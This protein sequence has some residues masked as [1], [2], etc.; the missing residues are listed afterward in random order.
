[1]LDILPK[2]H[3]F[4]CAQMTHYEHRYGTLR[5]SSAPTRVTPDIGLIPA[6][7]DPVVASAFLLARQSNNVMVG[8]ETWCYELNC[9]PSSSQIYMLKQT[10]SPSNSNMNVFGDKAFEE[11][12]KL[13]W[14][15]W[16]WP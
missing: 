13:Q 1:M 14:R 4:V 10:L 6:Y 5:P 8:F 15:H 2:A 7:L 16:G 11:V 3:G 12:T 9:V